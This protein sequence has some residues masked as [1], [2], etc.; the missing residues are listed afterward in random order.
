MFFKV[1]AMVITILMT[2]ASEKNDGFQTVGK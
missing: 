1:A 2:I